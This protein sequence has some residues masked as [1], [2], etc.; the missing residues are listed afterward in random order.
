MKP[1]PPYCTNFYRNPS[2]VRGVVFVRSWL[3]VARRDIE[4]FQGD[5][6]ER[7]YGTYLACFVRDETRGMDLHNISISNTTWRSTIRMTSTPHINMNSTPVV[8]FES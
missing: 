4:N 1:T 3:H 8:A 7:N 6:C 2:R 5:F